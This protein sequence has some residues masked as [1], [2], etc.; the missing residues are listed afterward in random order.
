MA[1]HSLK[2]TQV[3]S[4]DTGQAWV[5]L[6][7]YKKNLPTM[8]IYGHHSSFRHMVNKKCLDGMSC[9]HSVL[10]SLAKWNRDLLQIVPLSINH[11]ILHYPACQC[12]C[13]D[14]ISVLTVSRVLYSARE[15]VPGDG[16]VGG[17]WRLHN[18]LS[19]HCNVEVQPDTLGCWLHHQQHIMFSYN[20]IH[21]SNTCNVQLQ[22]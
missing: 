3:D 20:T 17:W 22:C 2:Q 16:M 10:L 14:D 18:C 11:R 13:A 12:W 6:L 8:S 5:P 19:D 21:P 1:C 15:V 9:T 7:K 4:P